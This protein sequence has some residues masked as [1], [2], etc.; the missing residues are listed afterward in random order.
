VRRSHLLL[1]ALLMLSS[2]AAQERPEGIVERWLL[3]LNQGSAGEP[4]HYAPESL[5]QT[6]LPDWRQAEPGHFDVIEVQPADVRGC[7]EAVVGDSCEPQGLMASVPFN[8][9]DT[10]GAAFGFEVFLV[11]HEGTWQAVALELVDHP[12]TLREP[13]WPSILGWTPWVV[14]LG[15]GVGLVIG[16]EGL[17][18]FVRRRRP[19]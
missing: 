15:V 7:S 13:G 16:G 9:E 10:R 2:C 11:Q 8:L 1:V 5:S 17:M 6:V 19:D 4:G 14:A 3:A 12:T 18:R